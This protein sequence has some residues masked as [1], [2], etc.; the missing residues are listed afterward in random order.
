MTNERN[1]FI[2]MCPIT[3]QHPEMLIGTPEVQYAKDHVTV[4]K[5]SEYARNTCTWD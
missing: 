3:P 5:E 4:D 1:D 2:P